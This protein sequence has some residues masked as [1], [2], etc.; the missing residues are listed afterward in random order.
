MRRAADGVAV[1]PRLLRAPVLHFLLL[2]GLL[3]A[4]VGW[5]PVRDGEGPGIARE[6]LVI[7]VG[8]IEELRQDVI[9]R[10]GR[11]P[12][13][14]Q[15]RD[16]IAA[17]IDEE[18]L[19]REALAAGLDRGNTAIRQ[20]LV[21]IAGFVADDQGL[22]EKALYALALDLGLD[23]SDVVVRRQLAM[24]MRLAAGNTPLAGEMPPGDAELE[25]YLAAHRD[26]FSEPA[27][28]RLTHV[29]LSEDRRGSAGET[30]ARVLADTLRAT[31][32]VPDMA[33]ESGDP[34]LRGHHLRWQTRQGLRSMLGAEF[35][36][37]V[38]D[39]EP[40]TWSDPIR[41]PY[42]WHLV[43]VHDVRPAVTPPLERVRD[44]VMRA[45][46]D[47]RRDW[48]VSE[49]LKSMRAGYSIDIAPYQPD[50]AAITEARDG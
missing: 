45:V 35:A 34:F 20:R 17:A 48:R 13:P 10:S 33:P 14:R 27:R 19:Y 8:Q 1:I 29:Y 3:Y 6:R 12:G 28:F 31:A 15:L 39:L 11:P 40:G 47:A 2:G 4:A 30:D 7:T 36:D 16:A 46:M 5:W 42:G 41:S 26:R 18:I 49:T 21:K 24:T 43:W 25:A 50:A 32:I 38:A 37:A 22:D 44:D 23:R 9:T